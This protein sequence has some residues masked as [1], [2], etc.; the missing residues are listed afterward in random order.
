MSAQTPSP[1]IMFDGYRCAALHAEV[2]QS[3][4]AGQEDAVA[5]T[6]ETTFIQRASF[7]GSALLILVLVHEHTN[8]LSDCLELV[9]LLRDSMQPQ[10]RTP[11]T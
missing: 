3:T 4:A 10:A 6:G 7:V 8:A 1:A 11:E 5:E 2:D 9:S